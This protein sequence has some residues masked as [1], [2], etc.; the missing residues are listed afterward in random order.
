M[1]G[2]IIASH[3]S[4]RVGDRVCL[5]KQGADPRGIFGVGTIVAGPEYTD[6]LTDTECRQHRGLI[7]FERLVNPS[8]GFLLRLDEIENVVLS[9]RINAQASRISVPDEIVPEL[10]SRLLLHS[11]ALPSLGYEQADDGAF[12]ATTVSKTRANAHSRD[13]HAARA[14]GQESRVKGCRHDGRN[15]R[16]PAHAARRS[17]PGR[18]P[19]GL[20]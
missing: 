13:P 14:D 9:S 20:G 7:R 3:V 12:G 16:E 17:T 18:R 1:C 15:D 8:E 6:S 4:A 11:S 5:F 19:S 2:E 10:E